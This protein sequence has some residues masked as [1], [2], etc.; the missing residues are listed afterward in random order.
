MDEKRRELLEKARQL[1][2]SYSESLDSYVQNS[3]EDALALSLE[4]KYELGHLVSEMEER[5]EPLSSGMKRG[6]QEVVAEAAALAAPPKV[7]FLGPEGTFTSMAARELTGSSFERVAVRTIH[8][9]FRQVEQE[10]VDVGVVPI[11]NSLEGAVS[12]TLDE[13]VETSL[14]ILAEKSFPISFVLAG[15]ASPDKIR[16]LYSHPQPLGQCKEWIRTHL[17]KAQVE[18]AES[19]AR[20]AELAAADTKG[21]AIASAEAASLYSL[22]IQAEAI[23]DARQNRTRFLLIGR[24]WRKPTGRDKTSLV[25][26]IKDDPG[27]LYRLLRPFESAGINMTKIESRPDKKSM[28]RYNFFID[29]QGH[30]DDA[31]IASA[32]SAMG[33]ETSFL[34]VLGSYPEDNE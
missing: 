13:L 5:G 20:A 16:T 26:A 23:E 19:T 30:R 24:Q 3:G 14:T 8:D 31:E 33:N 4:L 15:V 25:C 6:L 11:E 12:F 21:A 10:K 9:V 29:F 18:V 32:L 2:L 7:A 1:L 22:P 27:A 17:P 34:K 28:W